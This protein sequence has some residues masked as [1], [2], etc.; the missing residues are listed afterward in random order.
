M[1]LNAERLAVL[2]EQHGAVLKVWTRSR[3]GSSEDVVQEAFCRLAVAEPPP[4]NPVAWLYKVCRNL[5]EKQRLADTRRQRRERDHS[6]N[7]VACAGPIEHAERAEAVA[8][9]EQLEETLR[10]VLVARIWGGLHW[11]KWLSCV[12]SPRPQH[13]A[14]T[15]PH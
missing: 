10:E 4:D 13:F 6:A 1:P 12:G 8:A 2:I 5:A 9:V 7:V 15:R 14:G 11:K 3:C